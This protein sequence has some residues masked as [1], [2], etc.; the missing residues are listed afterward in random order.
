MTEIVTLLKGFITAALVD[1]F[2][3]FS[4]KPK[5]SSFSLQGAIGFGLTLT[6][7]VVMVTEQ[8]QIQSTKL[9]M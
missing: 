9:L 4:F 7:S 8:L 6:F 1:F 5:S 2:L 3:S